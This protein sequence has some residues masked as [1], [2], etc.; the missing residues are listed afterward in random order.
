MAS[1]LEPTQPVEAINGTLTPKFSEYRS[2]IM[3][4]DL[5]SDFL[6]IQLI[7]AQLYHLQ[8]IENNANFLGYLTLT[9]AEAK[10]LKNS[11]PLGLLRMDPYVR[12]HIGPITHETPVAS[13]G[14]KNPQWNISY[15]INLF[16]GM[17]K[18]HLELYDQRS[19]TE[20]S[21]IGECQ[22]EIR[23][24]VFEG[25]TWQ[26]WYPLMGRDASVDENQGDILLIMSLVSMPGDHPSEIENPNLSNSSASTS[27]ASS[28]SNSIAE[29]LPLYT[30]D[31]IR[32]I[33]EMFPT[34]DRQVIVDL[35][36]NHSG[37]KDLVVN[38]LLQNNIS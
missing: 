20:D 8:S 17:E 29:P 11:G 37:N 25:Q 2:R 31:D 35:L 16:K 32:T 23:R 22:I 28:Q 24:E 21:F 19:F 13:G 26:N 6:R 18:I 36:D 27:S 1:T 9:I 30:S 10:L 14:G 12:F 15:R 38:Y 34:I 33:E 4:G 5:P 3:L 7:E